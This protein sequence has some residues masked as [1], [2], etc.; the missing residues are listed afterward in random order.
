FRFGGR[1][2]ASPGARGCARGR[3]GELTPCP[4]MCQTDGERGQPEREMAK[5]STKI[6]LIGTGGSI[7]V[8]AR[9]SLD[10]FEYIE[11]G[12][13]VQVDELLPTFPEAAAEF[14]VVPV[15][16][17]AINSRDMTSGDWLALNRTI[18][19]V[20][21]ADPAIAGIVITHGTMVLEETAY[22][23]HL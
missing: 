11:G 10:H 8:A 17:G 15:R 22:F 5:S 21:A 1:R 23:L 6:A 19:D 4:S 9:H 2:H 13:I 14:D 20:V 7:S 12:R 18:R 16:F 3:A